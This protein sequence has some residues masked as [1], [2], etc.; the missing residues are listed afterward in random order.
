LF[1]TFQFQLRAEQGAVCRAGADFEM[2]RLLYNAALE[3]R[4]ASWRH[5]KA[6]A[7]RPR[8]G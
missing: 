1:L 5:G 3:Q 7:A 8:V 2:Q 4:I 6:L